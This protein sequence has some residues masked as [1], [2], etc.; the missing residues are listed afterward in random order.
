M[1]ASSVMAW[2]DAERCD[3]RRDMPSGMP[4]RDRRARGDAAG[5][6][7]S[8]G[9]EEAPREP[10]RRRRALAPTG[11]KDDIDVSPGDIW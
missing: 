7:W 10:N 11:H 3:E 6:P 2:P 5:N 8:G 4:G 9:D 1:S